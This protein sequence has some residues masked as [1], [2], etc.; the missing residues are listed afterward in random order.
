MGLRDIQLELNHILAIWIF[1]LAAVLPVCR[2]VVPFTVHS[3][4]HPKEHCT[5]KAKGAKHLNRGA[6]RER[7]WRNEL[8]SAIAQFSPAPANVAPPLDV[9]LRLPVHHVHHTHHRRHHHHHG[10]HG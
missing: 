9:D 2:L 10:H 8:I 5:D 3:V 6:G 7:L 1:T 4:T